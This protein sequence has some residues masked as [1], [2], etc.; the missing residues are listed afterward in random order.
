MNAPGDAVVPAGTPSPRPSSGQPTAVKATS[1][2]GVGMMAMNALAYGF[3]LVAA[4]V[5]GPVAFGGVSALLGVLIVA[6]VGA[7]ALQA[8]A[9][10]RLATA[11][12]PAA[13][14]RD[15]LRSGRLVAAALGLLLLAASPVI[16]AALH[17]DDW[18]ATA[19]VAV[20]CVP[21]T[22]MGAYAG[23]IQGQR[24]W[25]E[26]SLVYL[27]MGAGRVVG[28][29]TALLVDPSLRA[30]MV[31]I[32]V[33]SL[34]PAALGHWYA[35]TE[36]GVAGADVGHQPIL[37]ELWRN[38]HT[39]LAFFA[40]TNLDVLAARHLFSHH[41]AGIYAAG[42][43]LAKAC[44]FLPTF[45]LVVA[46]PTMAVSRAGR[47]WLRPLL[48][49][50]ALGAAA[51][52]GA[53]LLP[54]LAVAFAGGDEYAELGPHAWLFAVEGTLFAAVQILVYDS[55]A[56]QNHAAPVLWA[57]C[58]LVAVVALVTVTS[59]VGLVAVLIAVSLGVGL[60]TGLMP[61]AADPD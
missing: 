23:V 29:G 59:I 46:F 48:A 12:D 16:D 45:V 51:V 34:A 35:R 53:W 36:P 56:G 8:T 24:R 26:L 52:L 18:P 30:A 54:D 10:R 17:I 2:V 61:R 58:A 57:G 38:G 60:V 33:G 40:F 47:P 49:V 55:I 13:V 11:H 7:L 50:A 6:N 20:A 1:I 37:G 41:D 15:A 4:H 14:T 31:G 28:G 42:T 44:L 5:L 39:L 27:S 32:A 3:T 19:M 25:T 22:L 43:I 9:A 21:L